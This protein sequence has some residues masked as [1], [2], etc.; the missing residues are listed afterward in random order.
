[1]SIYIAKIM[2]ITT[3]YR[4]ERENPRLNRE[5]KANRR[6]IYKVNLSI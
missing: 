5:M 1:L 6:N 3:S 4:T 2:H